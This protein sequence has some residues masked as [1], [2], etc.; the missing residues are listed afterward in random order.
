MPSAVRQAAQIEKRRRI[1]DAAVEVFADKGFESARMADIARAAGVAEGTIYLYFKSKDDLLRSLFREKMA[2]V[3]RRFHAMLAAPDAPEDKLRRYVEGHLAL[4]A[5]QPKLMQV[6]TVE[7][8]QSARFM[9]QAAPASFGRYIALLV[10]VIQR[11][12]ASGVFRPD[13]DP[14]VL[15]RALFGAVDETA[16][17]W[18]LG[19]G[20]DALRTALPRVADQLS[21][22]LL[23][24]LLVQPRP[25]APR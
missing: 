4:V 13:A 23:T 7:L 6:L 8:R 3:L 20:P 10:G 19:A 12:Q 5:E 11:G 18:V 2:E 25:P 1:F 15:A 22:L 17:S 9:R 24:G 16:R 21:G 14:P